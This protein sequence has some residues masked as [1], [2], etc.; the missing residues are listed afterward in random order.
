MNKFIVPLI[1]VILLMLGGFVFWKQMTPKPVTSETTTQ[2]TQSIEPTQGERTELS[3]LRDLLAQGVTQQCTYAYTDEKTGK[4]EGIML[5]ANGKVRGVYTLTDPKGAV[6]KGNMINDG[7]YSYVWDDTTKTG[8]KVEMTAE[9]K[10]MGEDL[11]ANNPQVAEM[12]KKTNYR[13]KPWVVDTSI[14][15]PPT[16]VQFSDL[17][18]MME[19]LNVSP[20][21]TVPM[22][23]STTDTGDSNVERCSFCDTLPSEAQTACRSSMNCD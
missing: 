3:T 2:I 18:K 16:D 10:K 6:T 23:T 21:V 4:S 15:I 13:C 1:I 22:V 20:N 17:S 14:F 11:S 9:L 7:E 12:N 8:M 19:N 5:I